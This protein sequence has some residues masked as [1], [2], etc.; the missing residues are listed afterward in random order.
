M[1]T[2]MLA[3]V[4]FWDC[5]ECS[6]KYLLFAFPGFL[7]RG[8]K[9]TP[10]CRMWTVK[11]QAKILWKLWDKWERATAPVA[12]RTALPD[13]LGAKNSYSLSR[14]GDLGFSA[15]LLCSCFFWSVT[16]PSNKDWKGSPA[17]QS[18]LLSL[19]ASELHGSL[20][21]VSSFWALCSGQRLWACSGE[22]FCLQLPQLDF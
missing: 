8:S 17:W 13:L 2:H 6:V 14:E 1:Q 9:E 15:L 18:F 11:F 20:S 12:G 3:N 19:Y 5:Q 7:S 16:L 22:E 21:P 4:V 10:Q